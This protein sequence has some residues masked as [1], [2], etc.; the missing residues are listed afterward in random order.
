MTSGAHFWTPAPQ[1]RRFSV[2]RGFTA[3]IVACALM[4]GAAFAQPAPP[5][6]GGGPYYPYRA[7]TATDT[8]TMMGTATL[9]PTPRGA[10]RPVQPWVPPSAAS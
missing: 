3:G 5:Y 8:T 1:L 10:A 2:I 4:T 9:E 7:Y 6:Y